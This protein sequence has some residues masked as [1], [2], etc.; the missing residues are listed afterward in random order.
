MRRD[1]QMD[2][3]DLDL[4]WAIEVVRNH[5]EAIQQLTVLPPDAHQ[6]LRTGLAPEQAILGSEAF[7]EFV[8]MMNAQ[9]RDL[10]RYREEREL[11]P[12]E[13]RLA[14]EAAMADRLAILRN[15]IALF[16][17]LLGR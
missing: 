9:G 16:K 13:L 2:F 1:R 7:T 10:L 11:M 5:K 6:H 15:R 3:G 4:E 14:L 12:P 17:V 8:A